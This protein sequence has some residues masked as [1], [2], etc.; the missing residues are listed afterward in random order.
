MDL[1][2]GAILATAEGGVF[3][4]S[5][6]G[7]EML[8]LG[9]VGLSPFRVFFS[10]VSICVHDASYFGLTLYFRVVG[11]VR[12]LLSQRVVFTSFGYL[13]VYRMGVCVVYS[14]AFW[15]YLSFFLGEHTIRI[16]MGLSS[17]CGV[18][19]IAFRFLVPYGAALYSGG[20]VFAIRSFRYFSGSLLAISG[21]VSQD[22]VGRICSTFQYLSSYV[23]G[24]L[25]VVVS[26]PYES[27]ASKP[28]SGASS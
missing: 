6:V 21:I 23:C 17:I 16:F 2:H 9:G 4:S 10:L 25:G 7:S 26:A 11:G 1:S 8:H 22:Y 18:R 19:R 27:A 28:Y 24:Y 3:L 13:P 14:G 12:H 20:G 5:A 15:E